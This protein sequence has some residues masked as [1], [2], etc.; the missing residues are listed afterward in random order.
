MEIPGSYRDG[1]EQARKVDAPTADLYLKHTTI[2]DPDAD[3]VMDELDQHPGRQRHEWIGRG[4]EEGPDGLKDAPAILRDFFASMEKVP[5][6]FDPEASLAGCQG[7][8]RDSEMFIGSFVGAVLIEGF[9][10]QI[11]KSFSITGRVVDQGVRRL[12]QNNRHLV[13]IFMPGGLERQSDGWKL[14]VRIRMVHAQVRHLLKKSSEWETA[15]W[16]M[17]LSAAHI[18]FATD[19]FS[20]LL[21][22]RASQLGVVLPDHERAAFMMNWRYS[23]HLMG[24]LPEVLLKDEADALNFHKIGMMCEPPPGLEAQQMANGLINAAPIVAGITE[25]RA[26]KKLVRKIYQISRSLIGNSMADE[27]G[28]PPSRTFGVIPMLRFTNHLSHTLQRIF[29]PIARW[30]RSGQF[31]KMLELSHFENKGMAYRM[32]ERIHAEE[33][34][35][36]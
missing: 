28:Y 4:I 35:E 25:E 13:E 24:V 18:A 7:F 15:E 21:L 6:W 12:K 27:L 10:T 2:G 17:P 8:H 29:P 5:E 32:P 14:S 33:D 3:A 11:S 1:Y 22:K 36:I 23:G 9:S 34:K 20:A 16:G 19:A 26:R 31:Q 30:R